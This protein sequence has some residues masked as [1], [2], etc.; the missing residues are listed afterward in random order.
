[1][2]FV[3]ADIIEVEAGVGDAVIERLKAMGHNVRVLRGRGGLG[4]AHGLRIEVGPNGKPVKFAG[5][6]DP[7]G[8]G[9]AVGY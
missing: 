7:R 5:A 3:E 8:R 2:S 4:N 6:A 1:V 9:A